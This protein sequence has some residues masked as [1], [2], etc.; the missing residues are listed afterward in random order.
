MPK[1]EQFSNNQW[2]VVAF[3]FFLS[4][5]LLIAMGAARSVLS[6]IPFVG[7]VLNIPTPVPW[8]TSPMFFVMPIAAFFLLFFLVDWI[9]THFNTTHAMHPL[10]PVLFFALGLI[11]FYVALF[12][13]NSNFVLLG[14][15]NALNFDFWEKLRSNAFSLFLWGG[16]FGWI[17]RYAVEK[18]KL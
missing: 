16:V 1:V 17:A 2:I 15:P 9:N 5:G 11:A 18:I 6:S 10:F 8:E 7:L 14:D 13:Y 3:L 12:W 4:F